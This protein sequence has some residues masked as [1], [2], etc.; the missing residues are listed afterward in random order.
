MENFREIFAQLLSQSKLTKKRIAEEM[1]ITRE[2]LY[3]LANK[4]TVDHRTLEMVCRYFKISPMVFFDKDM[5]S[6]GFGGLNTTHT[7]YNNNSVF[8]PATMNIGLMNE[9]QALKDLVQEK[10]RFI[11][12]LMKCKCDGE[13]ASI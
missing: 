4:D 10:E 2:R 3:E 8:A 7:E 1:G 9:I 6:Y 12:F 11:Q 5:M 13:S